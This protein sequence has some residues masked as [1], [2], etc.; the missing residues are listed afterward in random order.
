MIF[1]KKNSLWSLFVIPFEYAP[2][3]AVITAVQKIIDAI[4][5]AINVLV[6]AHFINTAT[7]IFEGESSFDSVYLPLICIVLVLLFQILF[8]T[9]T[10]YATRKM[11]LQLKQKIVV[12]SMEKQASF[13]FAYVDNAESY[14]MIKRIF[15]EI[16][17]HI[18]TIYNDAMRAAS[19]VVRFV[20]IMM[21]FVANG[22][23]WIGILILI[24]SVPMTGITYKNGK[25]IYKFYKEEFPGKMEMYHSTYILKDR[26]VV[27]ERTLF[28]F[29]KVINSRWKNMQ[30][31]L[32][33]KKKHVNK[34]IV[35]NRY[36]SRFIN[37][38]FAM[39]IIVIMTSSV[40]SNKITVG[41]YI[42]LITNI[43]TLIDEV[44]STAMDWANHLAQEK[45]FIK[46]LNVVCDYKCN[47]DYLDV[48]SEKPF[49]LKLLEFRNVV[50]KYPGTD[51]IVL[52]N[53]SF[54]ITEGGHYA[55]VGKNGAG[56]STIIKLL[57]GLY[58]EYE[59][60][61][62]VNGKNIKDYSQAERKQMFG[63][64]YQDFAKYEL[65]LKDNIKIGDINSISWDNDEK[66]IQ[67]LSDVG[68]TELLEKLPEAGNTFLGKTQENGQDLSGGE[69]QRVAVARLLMKKSD[70]MILDEPTASLDPLAESMLYEQFTSISKNKTTL[71]I[72][73]RLGS[74]KIS[75]YIFVIDG[76]KVAESGTHE[77]LMKNGGLYEKLYSE[78]KEWYA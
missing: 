51:R 35:F 20:S 7:S 67:K 74:I 47:K 60:V 22:L 69:W 50:F 53:I 77:E 26:N 45:E 36:L 61:I 49:S 2:L 29:S 38:F 4:I 57:T 64:I 19:L 18:Y 32:Y 63:I 75:D 5:P 52:D 56:K 48:P 24:A 46:D 11:H 76:G 54:K 71:L 34:K 62:L 28:G 78:Q 59:G 43:I 16:P 55:F 31:E 23:W 13:D 72:S 17:S 70:F 25:A 10:G 27:D 73:H 9:I 37:L 30:L 68:L 12:E 66:Y 8:G 3:L 33:D 39:I 40:F 44:I 1:N 6:I 41:L 21:V 42:A 58:D 15:D 65:T 14:M